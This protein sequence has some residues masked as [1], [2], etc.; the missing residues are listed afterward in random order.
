MCVFLHLHASF[1]FLF[2]IHK[3]FFCCWL[4]CSCGVSVYVL[5]LF[6]FACNMSTGRRHVVSIF[7][8]GQKRLARD[9]FDTLPPVP[10]MLLCRH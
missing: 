2:I 9:V 8:K 5:L 7:T 6:D 4:Y 1:D 3:K 10:A